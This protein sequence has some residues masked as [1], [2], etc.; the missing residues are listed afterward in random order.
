MKKTIKLNEWMAAVWLDP[1]PGAERYCM[2]QKLTQ[3]QAAE[4]MSIIAKSVEFNMNSKSSRQGQLDLDHPYRQFLG[5]YMSLLV[6]S[7]PTDVNDWR[8]SLWRAL[9]DTDK[10]MMRAYVRRLSG[11]DIV[12]TG[13]VR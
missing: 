3:K 8:R 4:I 10:K 5:G 2:L 11:H 7:G 6:E 12:K 13:F 9:P 1:V